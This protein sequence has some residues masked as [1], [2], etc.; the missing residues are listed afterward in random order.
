MTIRPRSCAIALCAATLVAAPAAAQD[1][2]SQRKP[3]PFEVTIYPILVEA[4]VFGA[5]ISLPE[6]PSRPD[7]GGSGESN[8]QS[9]STGIALNAAYMAGVRVGAD[10]WF[11][12]VRGTWAALSASRTTPRVALDSDTTFMVGRGGVRVV[13]DLW[14]T[15]GFRRVAVTLDAT[16]T[17][18]R[19]DRLIQGSTTRKLWDPLVG[20]EWRHRT[21][22]LLFEAQFDG[23]GFG[24]GTDVDVM[25]GAHVGVR[26]IPHTELRLGYTAL[27][28]KMTVADV[29]VG[30]FQR[31]LISSQKLHGPEI[32]LGIVF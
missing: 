13:H 24:V 21:S 18:L 16:L 3:A 7:D 15:G 32:G 11:G 14:V 6:V 1:P 17:V 27:Y 20:V 31:T 5:S 22:R 2:A 23:G 8:E 19:T 4:P 9:G 28:Y 29:S 30:S 25:G 26:L 10:R 12:D